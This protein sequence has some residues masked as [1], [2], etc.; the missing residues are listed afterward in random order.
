MLSHLKAFPD[1][2]MPFAHQPDVVNGLT[3]GLPFNY[4]NSLIF[5]ELIRSLATV[6]RKERCKHLLD[7]LSHFMT[8]LNVLKDSLLPT[9]N[10]T[11][12]DQQLHYVDKSASQLLGIT[13]GN[14]NLND[15][16]LEHY[17]CQ[18][19]K[20]DSPP[21]EGIETTLPSVVSIQPSK[22]DLVPINEVNYDQITDNAMEAVSLD[23]MLSKDSDVVVTS[24]ILD[25]SL[26][27]FQFNGAWKSDRECCVYYWYVL[28][29]IYR[30]IKT[31][32]NDSI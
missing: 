24:P 26:D 32:E 31:L 3:N 5:N 13:E 27:M 12:V 15:N 9:C 28:C 30:G 10:S 21:F 4:T 17:Q 11:N 16:L 18:T 14:Y 7:E 1:H 25:I 22:Y 23:K 19:K 2:K 20:K 29:I 8:H 6:K